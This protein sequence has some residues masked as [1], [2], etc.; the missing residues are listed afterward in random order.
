[1]DSLEDRVELIRREIHVLEIRPRIARAIE[2][3]VDKR[4]NR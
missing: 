1:L 2:R 4:E 3:R